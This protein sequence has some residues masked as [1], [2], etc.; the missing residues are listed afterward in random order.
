MF[1]L[2]MC[3]CLSAMLSHT[4]THTHYTC[5][6]CHAGTTN[7]KLRI[8]ETHDA[9]VFPMLACACVPISK[10]DS[11][12]RACVPV[13][14]MDFDFDVEDDPPEC[15]PVA[16]SCASSSSRG[17]SLISHKH[18][19]RSATSVKRNS[20]ISCKLAMAD[21][22]F[23]HVHACKKGPSRCTRCFFALRKRRWLRQLPLLPKPWGVSKRDVPEQHKHELKLSWVVSRNTLIGTRLG[24]M[25]CAAMASD[26]RKL[27]DKGP[28][29]F[30]TC[31]ATPKYSNL[32]R[33]SRLREHRAAVMSYLG[34]EH[35]ETGASLMHAP[36][37]QQFIAVMDAV[38]DGKAANAA[39]DGVGCKEKVRQMIWCAAEAC[40]AL[41]RNFLASARCVVM[42]RD[43]SDGRLLVMYTA[44]NDGL[45]TMSG[46]F[47]MQ[48]N[49]KQSGIDIAAHTRHIVEQFATPGHGAP[50]PGGTSKAS[51]LRDAFKAQHV[52]SALV[53]RVGQN[54]CLIVVDSAAN[55][56]KAAR[57]CKNGVSEG[58]AAFTPNAALRRDLPHGVRRSTCMAR[59]H[60][61]IYGMR[62]CTCMLVRQCNTHTLW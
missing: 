15:A 5:A 6:F 34:I 22:D 21:P 41:A 54:T 62:S 29:S 28:R 31:S 7:A 53:R 13:Q 61:S 40:R 48:R 23:E 36:T 12:P 10:V 25:A 17:S 19:Q 47:G 50:L 24:C 11:R 39:V 2:R 30:A 56:L 58:E 43:E 45:A 32:V 37:H 14:A 52:D 26:N 57:L 18:R 16:R 20:S 38:R 4:H 59:V 8:H 51:G 35:T 33:H 44:A 3:V 42:K 46:L 55:E 49:G 27:H 60:A 9:Y 1:P